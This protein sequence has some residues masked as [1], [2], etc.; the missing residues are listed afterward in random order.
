MGR[1][2]FTPRSEPAVDWS[3]IGSRLQE[4]SAPARPSDLAAEPLLSIEA[5]LP[6]E[7]SATLANDPAFFDESPATMDQ[8]V[9]FPGDPRVMLSSLSEA[10]LSLSPHQDIITEFQVA[11]RSIYFIA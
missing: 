5:S 7:P 4:I 6:V 1:V 9:S 8:A 11:D 3:E 10:V 2:L